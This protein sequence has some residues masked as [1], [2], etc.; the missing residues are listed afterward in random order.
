MRQA[1]NTILSTFAKRKGIN[2]TGGNSLYGTLWITMDAAP[3]PSSAPCDVST[4]EAK[5]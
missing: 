5:P 2:D 1:V 4:A 3:A